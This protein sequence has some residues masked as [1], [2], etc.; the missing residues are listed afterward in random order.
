M[1]RL[2]RSKS[3]GL[4]GVAE[5]ARAPPSPI[6]SDEDGR[7]SDEEEESFEGDDSS[8]RFATTPF[9][10]PHS[11]GGGSGGDNRHQFAIVDVL[12]AALRKSLVTCSV[13]REEISS[14]DISY[15]TEVRHVSHVTFDRFHGFLG[16]PR[17]LQPEVPRKAPSAR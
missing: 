13:E 7:T 10:S 1:T 6:P 2:F 12:V 11:G 9:I 4:I 8:H 3:C 16:L 14:L 15:P 5:F 17:E